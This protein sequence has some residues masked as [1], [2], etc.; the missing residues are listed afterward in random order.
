MWRN[1]NE[2]HDL[3]QYCKDGAANQVSQYIRKGMVGPDSDKCHRALCFASVFSNLDCMKILLEW[4]VSPNSEVDG[5]Q[6][7]LHWCAESNAFDSAK[8]LL[9]YKA[10]WRLQSRDGFTPL[11]LACKQTPPTLEVVKELMRHGAKP[12]PGD[13]A[14]G[15]AAA[16]REVQLETLLTDLRQA[17]TEE[18]DAEAL[19]A[20]D[21]EVWKAQREHMR[22]LAVRERHKAGVVLVEL[23]RK[24]AEE[25]A[26]ARTTKQSEE[27]LAAEL[28]EKRVQLQTVTCELSQLL[29][30]LEEIRLHEM[31]M[32]E[33]VDK[34]SADLS[35]RQS[36]LRAAIA[37]KDACDRARLAA[38]EARIKAFH[39]TAHFEEDITQ[40]RQYIDDL[41]S[42]I[43]A[44]ERELE[45]W[46]KDKEAA[47]LLSEQANRLLQ[48]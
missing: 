4:G 44:A 1:T 41:N 12:G 8:L 2:T 26:E 5:G 39:D 22:L 24:L 10:D 35:E 7:A 34:V 14:N 46:M 18:P 42:E 33:D 36:E 45:N 17:A 28:A 38:E 43:E 6:R 27:E 47:R 15:L 20:A 29:K 31:A 32:K 30:D 9:Q 23:E 37:E 21:L 16:V 40:Q 25:L 19:A 48:V 13:K 3:V 11:N